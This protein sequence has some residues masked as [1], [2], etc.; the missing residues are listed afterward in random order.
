MIIQENFTKNRK[1]LIEDLKLTNIMALPRLE[2]VVIN[3]GI[4][5]TREQT[6]LIDMLKT[7]LASISGQ[8]AVAT[9]AKKAISG[10]K[11]QKGQPVG[12]KVT[13]RRKRM[14]DFLNRLIN[15]VLPAI[16]DFKGIPQESI[17]QHGALHIG[18]SEHTLFPEIGFEQISRAHGLQITIVPTTRDKTMATAFYKSIGIPLKES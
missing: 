18:L 1:Q 15:S 16:R 10:F 14:F 7:D 5:K 12:L 8:K 11:L 2:K 17:D 3:V 13:L 4:G 9:K 6:N